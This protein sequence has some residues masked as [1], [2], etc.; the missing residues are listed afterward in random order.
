MSNNRI[1]VAGY[2]QKTFYNDQIEY[3]NFSPD[4]VGVQLASDGGTP[5]FTMGNFAVTTNFDPK[6]DK[7]FVTH[8]FSNFVTLTDLDLTLE[9]A[10][11]L[12]RNND[13][14]FLNLDKSNLMY[15]SLFGSLKEFT[16]VSLEDIITNWPA[17]LYVNPIYALPPVYITQSGYTFENYTYNSL[18]D[19]ATFRVNTNVVTNRFGINTLNISVDAQDNTLRNLN[20]N[21][22]SYAILVNGSEYGVLGFTG[23]TTTLNDYMYFKVKGD[24]FSSTTNAYLTY[25]VKPNAD[26]EN[27]FFNSLP[28]FE[29]YLLNRFSTPKYTSTFKFTEQADSGGI[30][31]ITETLTWPA[32]DGYNIDFDTDEYDAFASRL[33]EL[34]T[35]YDLTTSNLMVRFLVTES[36]TD[37][38][39]TAVHLSPQDQDTSDQKMN[40]TLMIYG[41]EYD[42]L[43]K[44]I[45]GIQFANVVSYDKLN[46]MPDIYIKNLARV[47]GWDL[48]SSVLENNLL[49]SYIQPNKSTYEGHSVGYTAVEADI[50]LWRRIILNTPWIWK[51]KGT[52]KSIEF[53]FKF[54]GT[55][56]GLIKFNEY[57]Y[58]AENKIDID[59]FQS[60]LALNGLSQDISTYP[61][62]ND[63]Y[64]LPLPNTPTMYFQNNGLWYRQ[65]GGDES[66]IDITTGNNPHVGPYDG[67]YKY[68]NQFRE[69]IPDFS[70]VTVTSTTSTN[71]LTNIFTNYKLGTFNQYSGNTYVDI[72]TE[73]GIDFSDCFVVSATTIEDPKHRQDE[74]DC[75]CDIPENLRSMSICVDKKEPS[76]SDCSADIASSTFND[77]YQY[78]VYQYYQY[79]YN[80]TIFTISGNPVYYTSQFVD[81]ECCNKSGMIP[82]YYDQYSGNGTNTSPF[83][84]QNSGYICCNSKLNTC[85]CYVTCKWKLATPRWVTFS[86]FNYLQFEKENGTKVLTSQD[87]C[88]CIPNYTTPVYISASTT[89]VGYACQLTTSGQTDVDLQSSVIYQTY[90]KRSQGQIGCSAVYVPP[91][92]AKIFGVVINNGSQVGERL[93][94]FSF[95]D[96]NNS[97]IGGDFVNVNFPLSATPNSILSDGFYYG[98]VSVPSPMTG[99]IL[100]IE[101]PKNLMVSSQAT[102]AF[103]P[104]L[105]HRMYY[106][107][108]NVEYD[109]NT[110]MQNVFG[111][112]N[113]LTVIQQTL[114]GQPYFTGQFTYA[115]IGAPTNLYLVVDI[116]EDTSDPPLGSSY[117]LISTNP[118][119]AST[120]LRFTFRNNNQNATVPYDGQYQPYIAN[121][122]PD[123]PAVNANV[124]LLVQ[125]AII[126]SA[127]CN[128]IAATIQIT[129][130]DSILSWTGINGS[131]IINY[132]G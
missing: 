112:L 10:F 73:D 77:E 96:L 49:K 70:A 119:L 82:Y 83:I 104:A 36:I 69:L 31:Y 127:T 118:N 111:Q 79:N 124:T 109:N 29:Y 122:N 92:Q 39:T 130:G 101:T 106:M 72:T 78:S 51:S 32:T 35:N 120:G 24:A 100:R 107:V 93:N 125:G 38:D 90:L 58:L 115:P 48:I 19:E 113:Q 7:R 59:L 15:Y 99:D 50:E 63:G 131:I 71:T 9:S 87:G 40:K 41:A 8:R 52:R 13:G 89:D 55:P 68:I 103:D 81:I 45:L 65:T 84:L 61:I 47:L 110:F 76:P 4:L 21:Y 105:G 1:K 114:Y 108:S 54:I 121:V 80:G 66:T 25:Y 30:I 132:T 46:N 97:N 23:S 123:L 16:R 2:A 20:I 94:S 129:G 42:E 98:Y 116:S 53:L 85:G 64:P 56:L 60:V 6:K 14:V 86:G 128:G 27:L 5:L 117:T 88:H 43:N 44:Y 74:T 22:Q 62:G 28:E 126:T 91:V 26:K 102:K 3:R 12:L 37:F 75:G 67:G 33:L 57:I 11:S 18:T 34:T 17:A 95:S